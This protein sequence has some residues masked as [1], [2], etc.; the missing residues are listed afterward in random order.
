MLV[1]FMVVIVLMIGVMGFGIC[2]YFVVGCNDV[3]GG[4]VVGIVIVIVV[5]ILDCLI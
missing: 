5:I 4:F 1:F 2:V 3:G